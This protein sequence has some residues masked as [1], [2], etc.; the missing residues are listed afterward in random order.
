MAVKIGQ[1]DD[2]IVLDAVGPETFTFDQ[3][4]R[5]IARQINSRVKIVYVR[6]GLALFLAQMIG[7]L[8]RDVVI[9][10]DEIDGLMSNLLI[11]ETE[12]TTPTR[13]SEW[14]NLNADRIGRRY[15]CGLG[16]RY[17]G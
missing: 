17:R 5:M 4:V 6:P 14:L 2:N 10:R 13:F 11:S 7:C 1:Q 3:L 15:I 16:R 8:V 12:T 9:T